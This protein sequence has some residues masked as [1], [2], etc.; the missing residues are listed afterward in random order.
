[1][2]IE[3]IENIEE[4]LPIFSVGKNNSESITNIEKTGAGFGGSETNREVEKA[5]IQYVT[6]EYMKS[7]WIVKSVEAEKIGFDLLCQKGENQEHIEV[8][9]IQGD[10]LSFIITAGEVK[11]AQTDQFFVLCIVAS[12]LTSPKL[13][14]FT[15]IEFN[16][17]FNLETISYR[18][19]LREK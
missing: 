12:A 18:A 13:Y 17:R 9:G 2:G 19:N 16:Q 15:A 4:V 8:K 11:R 5:A 1:M 10:L 7:N 6:N 14:K 3:L